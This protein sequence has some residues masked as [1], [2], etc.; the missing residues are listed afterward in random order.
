M[1]EKTPTTF[2]QARMRSSP[3]PISRCHLGRI[4]HNGGTRKRSS[5]KKAVEP[6]QHDAEQVPVEA[7]PPTA[8]TDG[9]NPAAVALGR[10]GGA[11]GGHAR[12][13]KLTKEQRSE[14]A[15]MAAQTRW[16]KKLPD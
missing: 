2:H 8:P 5:K 16:A 15:K 11:K 7:V 4:C 3:I 1:K 12:A 13:K 9:K 14:I 6:E 10:L